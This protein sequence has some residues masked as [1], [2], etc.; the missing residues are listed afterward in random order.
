MIPPINYNKLK[1]ENIVEN[2]DD[3]I[4]ANPGKYLLTNNYLLYQINDKFKKITDQIITWIKQE[5]NPSEN[6]IYL[7]VFYSM[8]ELFYSEHL[9]SC[10]FVYFENIITFLIELNV[11]RFSFCLFTI[12]RATKV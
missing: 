3:I 9:S 7:D 5:S 1:T 10:L 12:S 6:K 8:F 4:Q 2:I 11:K